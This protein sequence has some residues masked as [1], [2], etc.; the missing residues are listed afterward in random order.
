MSKVSVKKQSDL[1]IR[2]LGHI[3]Y[4][5]ERMIVGLAR[6]TCSSCAWRSLRF[7]LQPGCRQRAAHET[8]LKTTSF[9]SRKLPSTDRFP[10]VAKA[11]IRVLPLV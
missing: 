9:A 10:A 4:F 5:V 2:A 11:A 1:E 3:T 6:A 7:S 8:L